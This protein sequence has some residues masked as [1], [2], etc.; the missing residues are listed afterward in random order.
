MQVHR[1]IK[2][3]GSRFVFLSNEKGISEE[4]GKHISEKDKSG[5]KSLNENMGNTI[6]E[7]C[8]SEALPKEYPKEDSNPKPISEDLITIPAKDKNTNP[9]IVENTG[10]SSAVSVPLNK[11]PLTQK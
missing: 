2:G 3:E 11:N 5:P 6:K 10:N 1:K 8:S 9:M 7:A 4:N